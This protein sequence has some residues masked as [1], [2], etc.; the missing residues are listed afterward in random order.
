[1]SSADCGQIDW[2]P[3]QDLPPIRLTST[4]MLQ[5]ILLEAA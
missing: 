5:S 2:R 1:V 4:A 3:S